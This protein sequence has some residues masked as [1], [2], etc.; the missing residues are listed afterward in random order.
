MPYHC[1]QA[2]VLA[3]VA[4]EGSSTVV[5]ASDDGEVGANCATQRFI[6]LCQ[7]H[8][9]LCTCPATYSLVFPL[10]SVAS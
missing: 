1:P 6:G 3:M 10:L 5:T 2:D 7:G 8:R 9:Y 4:L